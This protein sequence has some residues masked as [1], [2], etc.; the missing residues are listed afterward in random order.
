MKIIDLLNKI[1]NGEEVPS[2]IKVDE[3]TYEYQGDDYGHKQDDDDNGII[4]SW[5][6]TD[7]EIEKYDYISEF[8]N[9][10][11]EIIEE[12]K[13]IEKLDIQDDGNTITLFNDKEWT[14]LDNVDVLFG[15]KI[16]ELI[17]KVNSLENNQ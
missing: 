5:L 7:N 10:E 12:D 17:D 4:T 13:K 11:V 9:D 8:L 2:K 16:N 6:F 15:N 14:I 3:K 1:A